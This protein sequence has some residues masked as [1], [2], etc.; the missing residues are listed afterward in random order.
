[1]EFEDWLLEK[2]NL[3]NSSI[4]FDEILGAI[5]NKEKSD[6]FESCLKFFLKG[7]QILNDLKRK[8]KLF[9]LH[10]DL[11]SY[12]SDINLVPNNME[13]II[14]SIEIGSSPEFFIS[15]IELQRYFPNYVNLEYYQSPLPF[16]LFSQSEYDFFICYNEYRSIEEKINND[17]FTRKLVLGYFL[18]S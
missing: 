18:K 7:C 14:N 2:I 13:T 8:D 4:H 6:V 9:E 11:D 12:D 5:P 15:K 1:M 3:P 17:P 16:E 10:I